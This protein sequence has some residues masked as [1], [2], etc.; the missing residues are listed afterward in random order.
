MKKNNLDVYEKYGVDQFYNE[1][2]LSVDPKYRRR[3]IG[4][5][6]LKARKEIGLAC[7]LKL[8]NVCYSSEYSNKCGL[9]AGY[10]LEAKVTYDELRKIDPELVFPNIESRTY[11]SQTWLF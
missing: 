11:T 6:L 9:N 7:G 4:E 2:G 1:G 10:T 5:Y 3:R 8:T